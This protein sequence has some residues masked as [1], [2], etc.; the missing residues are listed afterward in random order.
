MLTYALESLTTCLSWC[1][2]P[3]RPG[4]AA[5]AVGSA[6]R[7][8]QHEQRDAAGAQHCQQCDPK[9]LGGRRRRAP[10][11]LPFAVRSAVS[12]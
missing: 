1:L 12:S 6:R 11:L 2:A 8:R 3:C 5:E 10:A 4:C 9:A 7:R